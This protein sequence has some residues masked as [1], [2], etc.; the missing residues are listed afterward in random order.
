M[1]RFEAVTISGPFKATGP[2]DTPSRRADLHLP[3]GA[4]RVGARPRAAV[5]AAD[6]HDAGAARLPPAGHRRRRRAAARVL[7]DRPRQGQLRRRHPA[8]AAA[9]PRR[10]RSSC[11]A[12]SASRARRAAAS[13]LSHQRSRAGV[14]PVVLPVEQHPR[15]RAADGGGAGTPQGSGGARAAGAADAGRSARRGARQQLRRA[16]AVPAQPAERRARARTSSPTSTTTC[17]RRSSAR[18]SC[19]SSSVMREDRS[20][21]ELL[22]ADY[23]FVNERLARHYGIPNIYGRQFRRVPVTSD[24]RRGLLGHGSILTVTSQPNRTSPVL[25]GKWILDN[26][27]GTP[28]PPPPADVPP[29]KE[30][31]ERERPLTMREQMEEHRANP[32]CAGCHKLMDPLGFALENFDG[33]GAWRTSDAARA[34][35]RVGASWPTARAWT[36][37]R[38]CGRRSSPGPEVFV[39]TM[40]EKLLT[41]ALGRG[42]E[43]YDMPAVR[44]IVAR[45]RAQRLP[46]LVARAR[47]R[48]QR[49]VPDA[50]QGSAGARRPPARAADRSRRGDHDVHHQ[51]V[52]ASPDVPAR[53]GV[54]LALPLL[55][56]MVPALTAPVAHGGRAGPPLRR[57]LRA[58]RQDPE[59][60]DA[61]GA[62]RRLR[63]HADPEA[64]RS[65]S[66]IT[67]CVVSGLDGPKDPAAGGHATAPAMWLTGISPKK[68]EGE[69]VRNG[70]T[71]DQMIAKADRPGHAVPVARAGDRGLHRLRRRLRRRLQLHL[72][73]HDLLAGA[74]HAAADGDQ[75]ARRVRAAVRRHRHGGAAARAHADAPQHPRLG[76]ASRRRS[77]SRAS[78]PATSR[79]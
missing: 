35:R 45:R 74:D 6:P 65:R 1:P 61:G 67:S 31:S 43:H 15:R 51:D 8:G 30:N 66:A 16:V 24:A 58:A 22:T 40:T 64:A 4:R 69:D 76:V 9:H 71:I 44:A 52:V 78:A 21:L 72:H 48:Q 70:T 27:L 28:P 14:A 62:G 23:T 25:R 18:P 77:C 37:R 7:P 42:L 55:D 41:Y 53:L 79:G 13:G 5:R 50:G 32:A 34:D 29:L 11:S 54:T 47:H 36:A 38:R 2:G 68:T 75:P 12:P 49:P 17:G 33:V 39:G 56:A 59:P 20:V 73:E 46:F 60:V 57:R 3:P 10:A 19:S 63:V 26:L